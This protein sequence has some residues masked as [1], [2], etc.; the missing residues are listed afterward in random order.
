M[1]FLKVVVNEF[2]GYDY[3][4]FIID[5]SFDISVQNKRQMGIA[6]YMKNYSNQYTQLCKAM[7]IPLR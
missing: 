7:I 1:N 3:K 5:L 2:N 6:Y 4:S